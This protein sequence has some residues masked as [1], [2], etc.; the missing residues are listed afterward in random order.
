L[1]IYEQDINKGVSLCMSEYLIPNAGVVQMGI[2]R[3]AREVAVQALYMSEFTETVNKDGLDLFYT[4]FNIDAPCREFS[5]TLIL[6]TLGRVKKIDSIISNSSINWPLVRMARVDRAILRVAV[7][8]LFFL[9]DIPH[10]VSINEAIEVAKK[11]SSDDSPMFVN[12]ILDRI[13]KSHVPHNSENV[14]DFEV[15]K[16]RL[17]ESD[18]ATVKKKIVSDTKIASS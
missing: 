10:N 18:T 17:G 13:A 16:S 12:G 8:E 14:M 1:F 3:Q 5:S 15:E 6:G 11:F 9:G 4:Q 2:R 7:F